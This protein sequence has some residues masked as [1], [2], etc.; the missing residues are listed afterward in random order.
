[1]A[2]SSR[3]QLAE[4]AL[5]DTQANYLCKPPVVLTPEEYLRRKA[6]EAKGLPVTDPV[7]APWERP[8]LPD[9]K[10]NR[11]F[12]GANEFPA[13][14]NPEGFV[15]EGSKSPNTDEQGRINQERLKLE[16]S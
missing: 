11:K 13:R 7:E 4:A 12:V 14:R 6:L 10:K 16:R 3:Q 8:P 9:Y 5:K 2:R 1:M 15:C